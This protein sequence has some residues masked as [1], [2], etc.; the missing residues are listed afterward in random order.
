MK[1]LKTAM[2]V[3]M[4]APVAVQAAGWQQFYHPDGSLWELTDYQ[5]LQGASV[6][7]DKTVDSVLTL[8]DTSGKFHVWLNIKASA[9]EIVSV[10]I[11]EDTTVQTKTGVHPFSSSGL[12]NDTII[13]N[14]GWNVITGESFLINKIYHGDSILYGHSNFDGGNV[15]EQ[16]FSPW[17]IDANPNP[18]ESLDLEY[19]GNN[20]TDWLKIMSWNDIEQSSLSCDKA[21]NSVQ[22]TADDEH[23]KIQTMTGEA[24]VHVLLDCI[25]GRQTL[26]GVS[27]INHD[28]RQPTLADQWAIPGS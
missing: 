13:K 7:G 10:S 21:V 12:T 2:L 1:L 8:E 28:N 25:I 9:F 6:T 5:S 19:T 24:Y 14:G 11:D 4:L 20:F 16:V 27:I 23:I 3:S 26:K 18:T 22:A 17:I 15:G